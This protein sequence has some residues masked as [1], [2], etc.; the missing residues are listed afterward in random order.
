MWI[1]FNNTNLCLLTVIMFSSLMTITIVQQMTDNINTNRNTSILDI[2]RT[3]FDD[4]E[5]NLINST[6]LSI[7]QKHES[8]NETSAEI[9]LETNVT[10]I[11]SATTT[12][13]TTTVDIW[14]SRQMFVRN[15]ARTAWNAYAKNGLGNDIVM[16]PLGGN[17]S[18]MMYGNY[19]GHSILASMTTLW[20]MNMNSEFEK[21]KNWIEN[22][23]D[24]REMNRSLVAFDM[25]PTYIG[26]LLS[27]YALTG[28]AMFLNKAKE[29]EILLRPVF[30]SL[31]GNRFEFN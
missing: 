7:F 12:P 18:R 16:F 15:M 24:L 6:N 19:S 30:D 11:I 14:K 4:N 26:S 25:I 23:L 17:M 2:L 8:N 13:T 21:G 27:C 31:T 22:Q 29:I 10:D 3:F 9:L 20:I 5:N 28:D 1:N